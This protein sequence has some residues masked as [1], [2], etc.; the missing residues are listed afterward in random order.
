MNIK[1]L[2]EKLSEKDIK[3]LL[4]EMG[5][6]FY[7]EDDNY[8][9]TNTICHNGIKPKLY[10]YKDTKTFYCY[11]ECGSLDI[12][13]LVM[14]YNNYNNSEIYKAINWICNKLKIDTF[15][16]EF[17]NVDIISDWDFIKNY[18]LN[19]KTKIYKNI[20]KFYDKKILNIF[21]KL[22]Y[23]SWIEEGISIE[24]MNKFQIMYSTLNQS[25]IIPHF[26]MNNNLLGV[27]TRKLIKDEI[28]SFGKY[29]PFQLGNK[30]YNHSLNIN[31]YGLNKNIKGIVKKRKIMLVEAEKSVLQTDTMF[32]EDNFTVALCGNNFS[33]F[34]RDIILNLGVNEVIIGLDK[35]Y[36]AVGNEE[37]YKWANHI[38]RKI[39]DKLSPFVVVSVLWDID[40]L[41]DYKDSPT[42]KGKD[43]LLKLM[44]NKIYVGTNK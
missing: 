15:K 21:Q 40:N 38:K 44:E 12:I 5:A 29:A 28:K 32:G 43:I 10:F 41:L 2:K 8:W 27:R 35:Q 13:S 39:I 37:Y 7:Y 9:I 34:Q 31:L 26:D 42:D 20:D 17:G 4:I 30:I 24:T 19:N 22:Y 11:T 33:E 6:I 23:S 16:V 25:I 18:N 14:S 1:E 36:L 3:N